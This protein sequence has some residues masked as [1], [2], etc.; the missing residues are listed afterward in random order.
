M[1]Q[2]PRIARR[3]KATPPCCFKLLQPPNSPC[4]PPGLSQVGSETCFPGTLSGQG[5]HP[6]RFTMPYSQIHERTGRSRQWQRCCAVWG[7]AKCPSAETI[8]PEMPRMLPQ[9][10]VRGTPPITPWPANPPTGRLPGRQGSGAGPKAFP[11]MGGKPGETACWLCGHRG[12]ARPRSG[13]SG[14]RRGEAWPKAVR[15]AMREHS[16]AAVTALG[17][18]SEP[19]TAVPRRVLPTITLPGWPATP[20]GLRAKAVFRPV[21]ARCGRRP[22][23]RGMAKGWMIPREAPARMLRCRRR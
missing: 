6:R 8:S 14:R 18:L 23:S 21:G 13:D 7:G 2:A 10:R 5:S 17:V 15:M 9:G 19:S 12:T 1:A 16:L 22:E 4:K 20:R 3:G 11:T